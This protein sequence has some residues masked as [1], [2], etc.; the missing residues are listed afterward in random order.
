[1]YGKPTGDS[2]DQP[3]AHCYERQDLSPDYYFNISLIL[4]HLIQFN[5]NSTWSRAFSRSRSCPWKIP[6]VQLSRQQ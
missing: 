2:T 1:M 3:Y 4:D 5:F 6:S